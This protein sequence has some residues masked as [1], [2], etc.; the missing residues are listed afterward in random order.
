MRLVVNTG[1]I[2]KQRRRTRFLI[3]FGII[4]LFGSFPL[5]LN[6]QLVLPAYGVLILGFILFNTGMS[7]LTKWSR[8]PRPDEILNQA[9][10]R[11][12]DRYTLIHYPEMPG[13]RPEHVLVAPAGLV[14][15]T[16][17]EVI[18]KV[19]VE[20]DQW[21][22]VGR[23]LLG[24]FNMA[25]PPLGNPTA[26]C[27]RQQEVLREFLEANDLPGGDLI[28]GMLVFVH[29]QAELEVVS[30]DLTVVKADELLGAVRDLGT[31]PLLH[32]KQREAIV[33]ALSQGEGVEGPTA[34]PT[35]ERARA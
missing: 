9:L 19:R 4:C 14:V 23:R 21:Q 31:E 17:R 5:T 30:S 2:K 29:P 12:N 27:Q 3:L 18:G 28:E 1:Y 24:L 34:L 35:R 6:P 20:D 33:A 8:S 16:T 7:R 10:R 11:L 32:T 22:R 15:I 13:F 26:E 25:G